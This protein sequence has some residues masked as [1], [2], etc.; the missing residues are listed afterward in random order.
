VADGLVSPCHEISCNSFCLFMPFRGKSLSDKRVKKM[1]EI[2][3][4]RLSFM[5]IAFFDFFF[6]ISSKTMCTEL[7]KL[8]TFG[9]TGWFTNQFFKFSNVQ[10]RV[11]Q[12]FLPRGTLGQPYQYLTAPADSNKGLKVNKSDNN[13]TQSRHPAWCRWSVWPEGGHFYL[14]PAMP[15]AILPQPLIQVKN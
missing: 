4:K 14:S 1:Y 7:L 15:G 6:S 3:V 11:S 13:L 5:Q 8:L 12:S 2:I 9:S 10:I